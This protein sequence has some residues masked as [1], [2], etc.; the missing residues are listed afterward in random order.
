MSVDYVNYELDL[1]QME[2]LTKTLDMEK[3]FRVLELEDP[4]VVDFESLQELESVRTPEKVKKKY[5][6]DI[7]AE[8]IQ[9]FKEQC[10]QDI[11]HTI[12]IKEADLLED[13]REYFAEQKYQI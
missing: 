13:L 8:F 3:L 9:S 5:S 12:S 11:E 4:E 1:D 2:K 10:I 7:I 6:E